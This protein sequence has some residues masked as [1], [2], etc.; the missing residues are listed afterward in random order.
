M[1]LLLLLLMTTMMMMIM[2]MTMTMTMTMMMMMTTTTT[3]M[4]M[5]MTRGKGRRRWWRRVCG[6]GWGW[7]KRM[8]LLME[9]MWQRTLKFC[10]SQPHLLLIETQSVFDMSETKI[11]DANLVQGNMSTV[12]VAISSVAEMKE[13]IGLAREL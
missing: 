2:V 1:L 11:S 13:R 3:M 6:C 12:D 4:T 7:V 9:R 8:G 10:F 5:T